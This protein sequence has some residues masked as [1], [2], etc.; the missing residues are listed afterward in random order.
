[1]RINQNVV[2]A[3]VNKCYARARVCGPV[4]NQ[5]PVHKPAFVAALLTDNHGDV[6]GSLRGDVKALCVLR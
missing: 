3:V 6:R 4:W 2:S 1:M 5:P